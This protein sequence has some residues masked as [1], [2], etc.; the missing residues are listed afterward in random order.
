MDQRRVPRSTIGR[1]ILPFLALLCTGCNITEWTESVLTFTGEDSTEDEVLALLSARLDSA[2]TH[3][4]FVCES[5]E[6]VAARGHTVLYST[7]RVDDYS[8]YLQ[9]TQTR[10]NVSYPDDGGS[11]RLQVHTGHVTLH[12]FTPSHK[13]FRKWTELVRATVC[14]FRDFAVEHSWPAD[15]EYPIACH[16]RGA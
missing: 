15:S 1:S 5:H 14:E 10:V 11:A 6:A 3:F 9:G 8:G 4:G 13:Y 12:P 16:A 7:C 2:L